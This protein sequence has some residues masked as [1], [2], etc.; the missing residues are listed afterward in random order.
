MKF[1]C[2][3]FIIFFLFFLTSCRNDKSYFNF[4]QNATLHYDIKYIDKEKKQKI[5]KQ[6]YFP[7]DFSGKGNVFLRNDG[8]LIT[9]ES[10]ENQ[11]FLK[12]L[13]YAYSSLV[14]L[15][16]EK[17]FFEKNNV[18]LKFPVVENQEWISKDQTTLIMK[19]GYDRVFQ[20]LLPI[21]IRNVIKNTQETLKIGDKTIKNCIR[22]ES[23][24]Y[25][26]WNPG[27]PQKNINITVKEKIWYSKKFGLVKLIREETSDSETMGNIYYEKRINLK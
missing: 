23:E 12:N 1:L 15:P 17:L 5:Y 25:T 20:T 8:K 10:N 16:S 7:I 27:P 26:S 19:L 4:D 14:D 3:Y 18:L 22:I 21:D 6:S 2:T 24:G 11:F 13:S 9:L